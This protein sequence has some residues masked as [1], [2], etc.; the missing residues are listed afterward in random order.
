MR[1][2]SREVPMPKSREKLIRLG[3]L[4]RRAVHVLVQIPELITPLRE[5]PERILEESD[6]DEEATDCREVGPQRLRI[7]LD[8]VLDLLSIVAKFFDRIFW[9]GRPVAGR[10]PRITDPVRIRT[11]TNT[12][13]A[14]D[15]YTRGHLGEEQ[16]KGEEKE[17]RGVMHE[18]WN[19][20]INGEFCLLIHMPRLRPRLWPYLA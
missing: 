18:S 16:S 13:W 8:I 14:G 10:R 12:L 19:N 2:S 9:V 17:L 11:I 15:T 4:E 7:Y 1:D 20:V 6:D 3:V 5:D